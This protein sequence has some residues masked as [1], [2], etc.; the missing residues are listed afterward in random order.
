MPQLWTRIG[1]KISK[2][3]R[4]ISITGTVLYLHHQICL[5]FY[6][7]QDTQ[8]ARSIS[9][10]G[11]LTDDAYSEEL[12]LTMI[13]D[14]VLMFKRKTYIYINIATHINNIKTKPLIF[15]FLIIDL[16]LISI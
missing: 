6:Q 7:N 2:V 1:C 8:Y 11:L 15:F 13:H 14:P 12:L 3:F 16:Y 5:N 4:T 9:M 10:E